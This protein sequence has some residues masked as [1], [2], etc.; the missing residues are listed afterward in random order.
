VNSHVILATRIIRRARHALISD[1][2]LDT[3]IT[4]IIDGIT[5]AEL[6]RAHHLAAEGGVDGASRHQ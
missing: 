6:E 5:A 2:T 1:E 4:S 3:A